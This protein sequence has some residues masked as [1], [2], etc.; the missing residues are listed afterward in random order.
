MHKKAISYQPLEGRNNAM[1]RLIN[2]TAWSFFL[3]SFL[4][5]GI[6][7]GAPIPYSGSYAWYS[8][9]GN[10]LNNILYQE[11][12]F[13]TISSGNP[14]N[15]EFWTWYDIQ[16]PQDY[17]YVAISTDGGPTWTPLTNSI[18]EADGKIYG[19]SGGWVNTSFDLSA[20]AGSHS[21][22]ISFRYETD[23]SAFGTGWM[24]DDFIIPEIGFLDDVE[25]GPASWLT[26]GWTVTDL[27]NPVPEPTT[28]LLFGTGL[29]SLAGLGR[30]KIFKNN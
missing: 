13:S 2:C 11:F 27:V 22:I 29:I 25:S 14:L 17:G 3:F 23:S 6:S 9:Q 18:T 1:R 5:C 19:S 21:V 10:N 16:S 24:L 30:K 20:Y 8:G 28:I 4:L 7:E 15:L 26:G 12:D